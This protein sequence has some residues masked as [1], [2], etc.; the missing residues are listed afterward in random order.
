MSPKLKPLILPQLV[1]ERRKLEELQGNPD[2]DLN[3]VY[4]ADNTSSSDIAS[5][6][7]PT[8]SQRGGHLRYSSST[9]SLELMPPS[10]SCSD[11][12]ASPTQGAHAN[13]K[14]GK[15]PLP[16]VQEDPLEREE[17]EVTEV[18]SHYGL[19]DCLCM[20]TPSPLHGFPLFLPTS[21]AY[22]APLVLLACLQ[23]L[24][25]GSHIHR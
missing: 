3:Y 9:S 13:N 19:Y 22:P 12:P 24:T 4:F 1:E 6:V 23:L 8:F 21:P 17:E 16:D 14:S 11:S 15:R 7:T 25:K 18:P 2:A 5:P 10:S 20:L